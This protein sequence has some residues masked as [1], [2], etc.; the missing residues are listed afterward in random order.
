MPK[1]VKRMRKRE[2]MDANFTKGP[3]RPIEE[4]MASSGGLRTL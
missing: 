2:K 1:Q 4:I 3:L